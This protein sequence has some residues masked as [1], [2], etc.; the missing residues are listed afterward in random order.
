MG[1]AREIEQDCANGRRDRLIEL[2]AAMEQ[3]YFAAEE[4]FSARY[5][6]GPLDENDALRAGYGR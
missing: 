3:A 4:P 1:L 2:T 5:T 6:A